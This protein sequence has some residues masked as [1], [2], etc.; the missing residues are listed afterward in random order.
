MAQKTVTY[1]DLSQ[2]QDPIAFLFGEERLT[3]P[4]S[5]M[6]GDPQLIARYYERLLE[7]VPVRTLLAKN[8][9]CQAGL[10]SLPSMLRVDYPEWLRREVSRETIER[11]LPEKTPYQ[12]LYLEL[13]WF[14]Y[15]YRFKELPRRKK[16]NE[17][18]FMDE[19]VAPFSSEALLAGK[20]QRVY[21]A[22]AEWVPAEEVFVNDRAP[23]PE[24]VCVYHLSSLN[25]RQIGWDDSDLL[26]RIESGQWA[27]FSAVN[28]RIQ[29]AA[30][31]SARALR[32]RARR[33]EYYREELERIDRRVHHGR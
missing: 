26:G 19:V 13:F 12:L 29:L 31:G 15:P 4:K 30:Y 22:Q 3:V 10:Q 20:N 32:E 28:N 7:M 27:N 23:T 14:E 33:L 1:R 6:V 18:G 11:A 17:Y 24:E 5:R 2:D 8:D 9:D 21:L 16:K 25:M